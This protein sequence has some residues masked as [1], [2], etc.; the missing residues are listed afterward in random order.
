MQGQDLIVSTLKVGVNSVQVPEDTCKKEIYLLK[1]LK[2][3]P[4]HF[5]QQC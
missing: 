5:D 2:E 1:C 4:L 3:Q